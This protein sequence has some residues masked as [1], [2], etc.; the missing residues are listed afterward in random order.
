M[1]IEF[2]LKRVLETP[3]STGGALYHGDKFL[4][5]TIEDGH[6]YIK[7]Y[8]VTRIPEGRYKIARRTEGKFYANY[9]SKW[10]H[11]FVPHLLDVPGFEYILIH[12]GNSTA[13]TKGCILLN[14]KLGHDR[15]GFFGLDSVLAYKAFYDYIEAI[16]PD[17]ISI[18]IL[19]QVK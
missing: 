5:F 15:N 10:G 3:N 12:T 19:N 18:T 6:R 11:R 14:Q 2:T 7:E 17:E 9:N 8:G 1:V 13:N 4:C 16:N